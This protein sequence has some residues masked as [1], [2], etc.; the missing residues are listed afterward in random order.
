MDDVHKFVSIPFVSQVF[1]SWSHYKHVFILYNIGFGD[2]ELYKLWFG[3][4]KQVW[5]CKYITQEVKVP[6]LNE[7]FQQGGGILPRIPIDCV[8][9]S[10]ILISVIP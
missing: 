4:F 8:S 5:V 3:C 7:H 6:P 2:C 10:T 9:V 1:Y